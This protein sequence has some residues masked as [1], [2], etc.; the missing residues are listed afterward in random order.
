MFRYKGKLCFWFPNQSYWQG[1]A[2]WV[3][4]ET[5][6]NSQAT[7]CVTSI[8]NENKPSSRDNEIT[9]DVVRYLDAV[10]FS[11]F[12]V[13][14]SG[15][16]MTGPLNIICQSNSPYDSTLYIGNSLNDDWGVKVD[17][18]SSDYGLYIISS[19]AYGLLNSGG[20]VLKGKVVIG[21]DYAEDCIYTTNIIGNMGFISDTGNIYF[22]KENENQYHDITFYRGD[23]GN[24]LFICGNSSGDGGHIGVG[25]SAGTVNGMHISHSSTDFIRTVKTNEHLIIT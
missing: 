1:F 22:G 10:N 14:K 7:N 19:G 3:S 2:V 24:H 21:R 17:K 6:P 13:A 25:T 8:T 5:S 20:S 9:C 15:D 23:N 18:G 16:T 11:E 4:I 12:A